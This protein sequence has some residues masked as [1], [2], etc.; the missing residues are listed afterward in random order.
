MVLFV[1]GRV[2]VHEAN[3][4]ELLPLHFVGVRAWGPDGR[5]PT[6]HADRLMDVGLSN[7]GID[8][9]EQGLA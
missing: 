8:H 6:L 1:V 9:P 3:G 7:F 5:R 2:L 4:L